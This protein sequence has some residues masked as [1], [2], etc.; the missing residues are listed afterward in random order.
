MK[1][2]SVAITDDNDEMFQLLGDVVSE[3]DEMEVVGTARDKELACRMIR[4]REPDVVLLV[5]RVQGKSCSDSRNT[6]EKTG[7]SIK[8]LNNCSNRKILEAEVTDIIHEVGVPAHI[9]GYQYLREAIVM[10]VNDM[11]MLNSITKISGDSK[12]ISNYAK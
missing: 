4:E 3:N 8:Q 12:E 10:S 2:V 6:N 11:E 5:R 7:L 1:K 9:K